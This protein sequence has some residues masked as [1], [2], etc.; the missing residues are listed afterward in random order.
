M[1]AE[2]HITPSRAT[3]SN[4]LNLD[5]AKWYFYQSG[6]TTPQSVYT[7]SALNIAHS[8]PVEAD[9]AGKF[10]NIFFDAAL[11]YRGVLKTADDVTTIYDIDPINTGVFSQFSASGG[12]ALVGFLQAGTG[13]VARTVQAKLR[14]VVSV[15]DFGALGD[16]STDD[17]T[18]FQSAVNSGA[19]AVYVPGTS[20]FYRLTNE[21]TVPAGVTVYGDGWE[22]YVQQ[23]TLNKDV[24]IAGNSNTFRGLRLKVADGNDTDFV[25]CIYASSVRNLTVVDNF[26]ELG[27]QGCCG[28]QIRAVQNSVVRG[29]R[30]Y[31]GKFTTGTTFAASAA[32]I[33]LYS[34]AASE[35]H[36][37]DGN[38]C[39]SNNSQGI[40]V[41]ALGYDGDIAVTNNICVTLDPATCTEGGTWALAS[42]GGARRHAIVVGYNSSSVSG[43]RTVV[44]GNICRN[45]RWTGIYKQ[46]VASG[47]IIIT[48]NICDLNGYDTSNSLSGGIYITQSGYE[49]IS[50][51]YI[52]RFQNTNTGTAGIT[53]NASVTPTVPSVVRDNLIQASLGKGLILTTNCA[54]VEVSDN[55]FTSNVGIDIDVRPNAG[56]ATVAGHQIIGNRITRTSGTS[57]TGIFVTP[58][59]STRTM[60]IKN[61]RIIGNDNTTNSGN[62]AGV[63]I[64]TPVDNVRLISNEIENFYYGFYCAG[65]Y[66]GRLPNY[67]YEDNSIKDCNTGFVIAG[68]TANHT[69][70]VVDNRFYNVTTPVGNGGLG[71][72][73]GRIVQ[74]LGD[75]F[76]WQS[77]ASPA[78]GSWDVGDRS[79]NSAPA[80]GQPKAWA[81]TVAGTPGTWVSEG[82]L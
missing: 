68:T 18:A 20:T 50:G 51:N 7:T 25:N 39:L 26:L 17:T 62:N 4:G 16:G 9:A 52:T 15:K 79:V 29:N 42:T 6:T 63:R 73:V 78:V 77:T 55:V 54:L 58:E 21:I 61:N 70:P 48:D 47:A 81:C 80:V 10:P 12:S 41:D 53:V 14:D 75:K 32:D 22:S 27:D 37:I 71:N 57:V 45:T 5:G 44:S 31:A 38:F 49:I 66:S 34:G 3:S 76:E 33:L 24:F 2:L 23:E 56:S 60:V 74:R 67:V 19:S 13:A 65:Y 28:V 40:Y 69:V 35:R 30:I 8:N 72:T 1:A 43:P 59:S 46:G 36:I 11:S 64:S 82:N